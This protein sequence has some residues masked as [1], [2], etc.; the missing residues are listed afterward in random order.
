MVTDEVRLEVLR[1]G[2]LV[3]HNSHQR[4]RQSANA[5]TYA[6]HHDHRTYH[7]RQSGLASSACAEDGIGLETKLLKA[8]AE[9]ERLRR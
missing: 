1:L 6:P 3:H 2:V 7:L 4:D 5:S 9:L 8:E